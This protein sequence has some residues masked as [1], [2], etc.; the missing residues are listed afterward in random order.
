MKSGNPI[1]IALLRKDISQ[2]QL[3]KIIGLHPQSLSTIVC[4]YRTAS[5]QIREQISEKLG[6]S[7]DKLFQIQS[8]MGRF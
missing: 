1:R 4:G 6:V 8:T 5:S 3:A 2:N 7:E